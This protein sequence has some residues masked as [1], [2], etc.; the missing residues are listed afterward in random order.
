MPKDGASRFH[1][2]TTLEVLGKTEEARAA[3]EESI[4]LDPSNARA[5]EGLVKVCA[6]LGDA[7]GEARANA[8]LEAWGAYQ[9]KLNRRRV[10]VNQNPGDGAAVRRL[11]EAYFEVGKWDEAIEWFMKAIHIDEK[12]SLAHLLCGVARRNLEDYENALN[13]VLE[14]EFLAPDN[15]DPKLELLRLYA[16]TKDE[17][18]LGE[19]LAAV[20]EAAAEDGEA[21]YALAE[22]CAEIARAEDAERLFGKAAAKGV[23][24][25]PEAA[26]APTEGE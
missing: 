20:E 9:E 19:K 6:K 23:T 16:L 25:A 21:L 7:E 22:V 4:T 12:D 26:P 24:S 1:L 13:H 14:S 5:Y 11:G 15:L 10:K 18:S 17:K 3:Y 2:G 8:G